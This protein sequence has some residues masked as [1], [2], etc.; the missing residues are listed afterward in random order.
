MCTRAR[1]ATDHSIILS[2]TRWMR[3]IE[4]Y[5]FQVLALFEE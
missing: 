5:V 1:L 4:E 3:S 2:L